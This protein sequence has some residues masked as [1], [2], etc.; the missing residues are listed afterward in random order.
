[1]AIPATTLSDPVDLARHAAEMTRQAVRHVW[2][3]ATQVAEYAAVGPL[4]LVEGR[5]AMVRDAA[6]CE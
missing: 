1:M 3:H 6:S 2:H 5:G 4:I